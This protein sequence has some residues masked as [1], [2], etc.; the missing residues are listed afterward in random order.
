MAVGLK[1]RPKPR[2]GAPAATSRAIG[3]ADDFLAAARAR[4]EAE[5][6]YDAAKQGLL[7]WLRDKETKKLPDGRVVSRNHVDFPAA[8]ISRA[9]YTSITVTVGPPP[10]P[11]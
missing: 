3:F 4:K 6:A 10:A 2:R 9:A 1:K 7:A 5:A 8:T 11:L